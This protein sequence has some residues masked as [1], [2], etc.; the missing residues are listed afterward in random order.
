MLAASVLPDASGMAVAAY[1]VDAIGRLWRYDLRGAA[2][3]HDSGRRVRCIQRVEN[4]LPRPSGTAT[5]A[6]PS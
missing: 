6:A 1:A 4:S 2:P 5:A 3:S